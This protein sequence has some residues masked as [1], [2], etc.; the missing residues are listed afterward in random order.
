MAVARHSLLES[1]GEGLTETELT[2]LFSLPDYSPV[3]TT[4]YLPQ[5]LTL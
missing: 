5:E 4:T 1:L 2:V 3:L